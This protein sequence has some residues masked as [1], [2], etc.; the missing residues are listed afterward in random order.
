MVNMSSS[1]HII[2]IRNRDIR[3]ADEAFAEFMRLSEK[4]INEKAR[5]SPQKYK[6][7]NPTEL[8]IITRDVLLETCH[9]TP[10]KEEDIKLVGGQAFP[11]IVAANYYGVEVKS[12]KHDSWKSTGSSIVESTRIES[13]E[14]IYMMFGCLGGNPPSFKCKP[15]QDCLSDVAVTHSPRYLIDMEIMDNHDIFTKMEIN[16]ETFRHLNESEKILRVRD[17]YKKKAKNEKKIAMPWWMG[18]NTSAEIKLFRDL[19]QRQKGYFVSKALILFPALYQSDPQNA[20]I[21]FALWLCARHSLLCHNVRDL[22]SAGG[23]IMVLHRKEMMGPYPKIVKTILKHHE[24]IKVI[25][26]NPDE[27][28]IKEIDDLK[29]LHGCKGETLYKKWLS[30]LETQFSTY[31]SYFNYAPIV[32]F[33]RYNAQP[34]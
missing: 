5:L 17:Y 31:G 12:T 3:E 30:M 11:D 22:F 13:V 25:L 21:N 26:N 33:L 29:P 15:Y 1:E 16:Y 28:L 23:R 9:A 34:I 32:E 14:N 18:E 10:F 19:N 24:I 6:S 27:N 8:E 2:A 7:C 20:Y 4:C